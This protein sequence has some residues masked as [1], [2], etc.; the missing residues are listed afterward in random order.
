MSE[1]I[2]VAVGE[3][4]C[5]GAPHPDGDVVY[6]RPT[7]GLRGGVIVQG[8]VTTAKRMEPPPSAP[9][10]TAS[11]VETYVLQGVVEWNLWGDDGPIP[12]TPESVTRHLLDDYTR[13][14]AVANRADDLYSEPILGPLLNGARNSSLDTSTNGSTSA[15]RN[16]TRKPRKP[17]KRSSTTTTP[18]AATATTTG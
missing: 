9:E 18:T 17:S 11:L 5:P 14:E 12:V 3:C 13:A 10:I 4:R 15:P 2:E 1:L 8:V 7:L 16:G 6:L